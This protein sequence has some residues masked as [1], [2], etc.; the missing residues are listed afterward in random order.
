MTQRPG[1]RRYLTFWRANIERD[2]ADE[3]AF[4]SEMRIEEYIQRGMTEAEARRAAAHRLGDVGAAHDECVQWDE[5]RATHARRA[6]FV[7]G[8]QSDVRYAVRS[9]RRAPAW[10]AV[11]LLTIALGVG[12]S[13]TVFSVADTLLVRT[14]PYPGASRVYL[15]QRQWSVGAQILP[16]S[17]PFGMGKVWRERAHT[18]EDAVLA[19]GGNSATLVSGSDSLEVTTAHA[20][21]GFVA[22][23]EARLLQGRVPT[24]EEVTP[25]AHLMF[26]TEHLWRV[27]FGAS[28]DVVGRTMKLGG[29]AWT[30]VGVMPASLTIPSFRSQR[31]DLLQ[32]VNAT[33]PASG[34]ILVRLKPGIM[35]EAATAELNAI[36][37]NADLPDVRPG[38]W[39][40]TLTLTRPQ[41]WLA[42]R[43]PLVMLTAAVALLL[44]VACTNVAHLLLAR[45]A[46]RQ[47][48][49]AIRHALGAA[50]SRLVRQLATESVMLAVLGGALA[51]V[52]GWGSLHLLMALRPASRNFNAL[53]YVSP[54]G[55]MIAIA[56]VLAIGCGLVV[57]V[58]TAVRS[59]HRSLAV[60]LR[61]GAASTG[62]SARRL[63][64]L[65][66]VGEVAVSA[67][68]LVGALLLVHTLFAL[69]HADVGFD[70]RGLYAITLSVPRG[71]KAPDRAAFA[72]EVRE[73][74]T[75]ARG[76][77]NAVLSDQVPGGASR[78]QLAV[79]E[80]PDLA[81]D[82][83]D[84]TDGTAI[85]TVPA[86]YFAMMHM[87]L[88][89]GRTF[90][91]GSLARH[92]VIVSRS[93]ANH[94]ASGHNPV[95]LRIRNARARTWS[96]NIVTPGKSAMPSPDEP[97]QTIIGVVPDVVT[98]LR[99]G[100]PNAG[101]YRPLSPRDTLGAPNIIILA[102]DEDQGAIARLRDLAASV[103]RGGPAP[104]VV[105]VRDA[106]DA[107]LA[108]PRFTMRILA[109][110]AALGVALAAIGLFGV[111]SYSVSQ[112]T[113]EIGVRMTLGATRAS[114]ARLV[115]GD[116]VRLA[117]LGIVVG[118][119]GA[120]LATR[121]VQSVLYG[122]SRFDP[123]AFAAGAA[124]LLVVA[125]IACLAPML[126]ATAIDP[127]LAVR[128]E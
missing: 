63:R 122:V 19:S 46:S 33:E 39:P 11:A 6:S 60:D 83:R 73:L 126:R 59:A 10:T 23:A 28:P 26:L 4:H 97:W 108:E 5:I 27:A 95:G 67:T 65:L 93:L 99:Q 90:D 47:R 55:G 15:A 105:N 18:I 94:L 9:L 81:R 76:T 20:E 1:W 71:I 22:F 107:S 41:D 62:Y 109:A 37:K 68:L 91:D 14:L 80:T 74:F 40:M 7:D 110:F 45:G 49:L 48:E 128:A 114:I 106:I 118:L 54:D 21:P 116:G 75:R 56:A 42:I 82:P 50:R 3:L 12:A 112:R 125:A 115:V 38:P 79:W 2:V 16:S 96:S 85:F 57:G 66:V 124:L 89:A 117:A 58:L 102:R 88:L 44:L 111:I 101:L 119:M 123:I 84:G 30:V 25:D 32:L 34:S 61:V 53:T 29:E 69:E 127:A 43:Q 98:N 120:L 8:L 103:L 87:P 52:V 35:R 78:M 86:E 92:D 100:A 51:V 72:T 17:L 31:A 77:E 121:L 70:T 13:T 24:P 36:M 104:T 64:S 113:R